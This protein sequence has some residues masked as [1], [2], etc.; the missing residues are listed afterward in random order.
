LRGEEAAKPTV[1]SKSG[2]PVRN[3]RSV[4][5]NALIK[6]TG[7]RSLRV[8]LQLTLPTGAR[9]VVV[10]TVKPDRMRV[11]APDG[12]FLLIGQNYYY[13]LAGG[14]WQVTTS[15]SAL[16]TPASALDYSTFVKQMLGTPGITLTGRVLGEEA[17]DGFETV[18]YEFTVTD[19]AESGTIAASIGK[20]DGFL[21]RLFISGAGLSMK[22]WFT[23]INESFTIETPQL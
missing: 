8:Q 12:E 14:A 16:D 6:M 15:K 22:A 11:T 7:V 17:V 9:E 21:R 2:A 3:P 4:L 18:A 20:N 5:E 23:N 10:E 13:R 1:T 19:G